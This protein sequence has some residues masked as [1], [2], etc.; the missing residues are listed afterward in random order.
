MSPTL[1]ILPL[2]CLVISISQLLPLFLDPLLVISQ[3]QHYLKTKFF[4]GRKLHLDPFILRQLFLTGAKIC[5]KRLSAVQMFSHTIWYRPLTLRKK[6]IEHQ[7]SRFWKPACAD[8]SPLGRC[9]QMCMHI[10]VTK[11]FQ[12]WI[13]SFRS[14]LKYLQVNL[15]LRKDTIKTKETTSANF[16]KNH[17]VFFPICLLIQP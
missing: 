4:T 10:R 14:I 1:L 9:L 15:R 13:F 7:F 16:G 17:F 6:A 12:F 8:V 11:A 5:S 2:N 3:R